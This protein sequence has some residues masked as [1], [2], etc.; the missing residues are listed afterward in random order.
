MEKVK[1][2]VAVYIGRFQPLHKGH[3]EVIGHCKKNYDETL[4]LIGSCNKR[5]SIKNPF[6]WKMIIEWLK[7]LKVDNIGLL[8][9]YIYDDALWAKQVKSIV[10]G[11]YNSDNYEITLVGHDKDASSFYLSMFPEYKLELLPAFCDGINATDIRELL[12]THPAGVELRDFLVRRVGQNVA[13][14]LVAFRTTEAFEDLKEEF[15]YFKREEAKFKDYPYKDTLKFNC[16]DAVVHCNEYILLIQRKKA[17]GKGAWALPGGFVNSDETYLRAAKRELLEET[18]LD[19][20]KYK[21]YTA[22]GV[23]DHP[24]RGCGIPRITVGQLFYVLGQETLPE[25][26]PSDD[27]IEAKWFNIEEIKEMCLHDDHMDIINEFINV[28]KEY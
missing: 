21:Y 7:A 24:S 10:D 12:F 15:E 1:K 2:R 20:S 17:P 26:T 22:S 19:L 11:F 25:I 8:S 9:D 13:D 18:G 28:H 14:D 16:A 6:S 27:A 4:V 3:V 5:R 23:F